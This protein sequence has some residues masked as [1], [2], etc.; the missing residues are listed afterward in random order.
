M[1]KEFCAWLVQVHPV[2]TIGTTL[3]VGSRSSTATANETWVL[4]TERGPAYRKTDGSEVTERI[5]QFIGHGKTYL[6]GRRVLDDLVNKILNKAS[7]ILAGYT[8]LTIT[9]DEPQYLGVSEQNQHQFVAN[10]LVRY[11]KDA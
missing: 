5:I 1:I 4:V 8:I 7:V 2:L 3:F 11:K 10:L 6:D 9:G